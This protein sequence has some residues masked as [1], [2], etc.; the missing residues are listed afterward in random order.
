[1]STQNATST[2]N[3]VYYSW[4][5]MLLFAALLAKFIFAV[6]PSYIHP[7][8]F[9]QS[10]QILYNDNLPWEVREID[11]INR[12]IVPL[13]FTHYPMILLGKWLNLNAFQVYL[14]VRIQLT[15]LTWIITDWCIYRII[16]LKHE[17]I[18]TI[19]FTM[20]S[21]ITLVHQTHTFSNSTETCLLLLTVYIINDIRSHLEYEKSNKN[22]VNYSMAKLSCLGVLVSLGI[23]NRITFPAWILFPSFYL[24]KFAIQHPLRSLIPIL[25]FLITSVANVLID[26]NYYQN[27]TSCVIA[28]LNNLLYNMSTSNLSTHG[29]HPRYTHI[30][31]NYPQL[32]GPL[33]FLIFPFST[34]YTRTTPFLSVLSGLSILSIFPHQELRFLI[35]AVPLLSTLISFSNSRI[36]KIEKYTKKALSL[37]IVYTSLLTLFYGLFHQA[38]VVPAI[39]K[40]N[41]IVSP[42]QSSSLI[43]WRTYPPPTWMLD[44]SVFSN[45]LY[46]SKDNINYDA[47]Q[48]DGDQVIDLMG[49]H[50]DVL[51]EIK[52]HL[53]NKCKDTTK[54]YLI[55]PKNAIINLNMTPYS[56]EWESFWHLDMD[57]FEYDIH[58]MSTFTPGIG[59]Y[60]LLN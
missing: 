8:E 25:S 35:P 9:F 7:D 57:H 16:P 5:G 53:S 39:S 40:L 55:T 6:Q 58:G 28:P 46:F 19:L 22:V 56:I 3:T 20:T 14:F 15:I 42:E 37:W 21:Y 50:V 31:I 26:T 23:F 11:N 59:I 51:N 1:M 4:R 24:F 41:D 43:F 38:G 60:N 29:L 52:L 54:L 27:S 45:P 33:V 34:M 32:V 48:C 13:L 17:R 49:A 44:K 2:P 47:L 36:P 18:K 10:F 30:V 12:S